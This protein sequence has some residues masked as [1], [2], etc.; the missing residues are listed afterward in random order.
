[1]RP[2]PPSPERRGDLRT[3]AVGNAGQP[4]A[5]GVEGLLTPR[6]SLNGSSFAAR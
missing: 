2:E 4:Y 3:P 1:M 6:S 5:R